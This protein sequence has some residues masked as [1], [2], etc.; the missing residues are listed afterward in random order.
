MVNNLGTPKIGKSDILLGIVVFAAII[1]VIALFLSQLQG[2]A[3][4]SNLPNSENLQITGLGKDPK[5]GTL[6][7][8]VE[9]VGS[10]SSDI[11][12]EYDFEVND[13]NIPLTEEAIDKKILD[14]GQIAT[15]NIPFKISSNIPLVVKIFRDGV[16]FA[17]SKIDNSDSLL[18]SYVLTVNIQGDSSNKVTKIPDQ[19]SYPSGS[20]VSLLAESGVDWSF[21]EWS[22]DMLGVNNPSTVIIDSNKNIYANFAEKTTLPPDVEPPDDSEETVK[23]TF[24]LSGIDSSSTG[25]I[26]TVEGTSKAYSAFP[27]SLNVVKGSFLNYEFSE[28]IVSSILGEQFVLKSVKGPESPMSVVSDVSILAEF[29]KQYKVVFSYSPDIVDATTQPEGTQWISAGKEVLIETSTSSSEFVF[30]FWNSSNSAIQFEDIE[31]QNTRIVVNGPGNISANYRIPTVMDWIVN[32]G[33]VYLGDSQKLI[34]SISSLNTNST[35]ESLIGKN[36]TLIVT[37]PNGTQTEVM[38]STYS[39]EGNSMGLFN[40]QFVPD[41]IGAWSVEASFSDDLIFGD[42]EIA[43]TS[44]GVSEIPQFLVSFDQSGIDNLNVLTSVSYSIDGGR[45]QV[46]TVPF[47]I[48]VDLDSK[49]EYSYQEDVFGDP[50]TRYRL[51]NVNNDKKLTI[52]ES[53]DIVGTYKTQYLFIFGQI[54]LDNSAV[55]TIVMVDE[56]AKLYVD[57]PV[58]DWFDSGTTYRYSSV[59]SGGKGRRFVLTSPSGVYKIT[60]SGSVNGIYETQYLFEVFSPVGPTVAEEGWYSEGATVSSSANSPF[61]IVGPPQIVYTVVV[62][63]ELEVHQVEMKTQYNLLL[64]NHQ[65]LLGLGLVK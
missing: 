24:S 56:E 10:E 49:I 35:V 54:G 23:V 28:A 47:E 36:V 20:S 19:L 5:V 17:E 39:L 46:S 33:S 34:G 7:A 44:F 57:L 45:N 26:L 32:P 4:N 22:G 38:V 12:S 61:E 29:E 31:A 65:V 11:I 14:P 3:V 63:L 50:G 59:V 37:A 6:I 42:S 41:T 60:D 43:S 51:L 58:S 18:S 27:V 25:T 53:V 40:Y 21:S 2:F 55:G 15:I 9:N 8:Y 16:I 48:L 64:M 62:M 30:S 13:I 52:T 1:M